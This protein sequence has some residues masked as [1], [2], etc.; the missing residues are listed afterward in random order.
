M[1]TNITMSKMQKSLQPLSTKILMKLQILFLTL[2]KFRENTPLMN[3]CDQLPFPLAD[4]IRRGRAQIREIK[5]LNS[6]S[7]QIQKFVKL[8]YY[9]KKKSSNFKIFREIAT[10]L[11]L[12]YRFNVIS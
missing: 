9:L 10:S 6:Q 1:P 5:N 8:K 3:S 2:Q 4:A 12:R 11:Y 7:V